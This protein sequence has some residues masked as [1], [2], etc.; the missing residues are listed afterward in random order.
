MSDDGGDEAKIFMTA[1]LSRLM[2]PADANVAGNVHGGI[3]MQMIEESACVAA[4]R[5]FNHCSQQQQKQQQQQQQQN[6]NIIKVLTARAESITFQQ[7]LH[8]GDIAKVQARVVFASEHTVAVAV[9]LMAERLAQSRNAKEADRVGNQ[10]LLWIVGHLSASSTSTT[11]TS[12]GGGMTKDSNGVATVQRN[13]T[14]STTFC[15]AKAPKLDPPTDKEGLMAYHYAA[16]AYQKRKAHEEEQDLASLP[17]SETGEQES[18]NPATED[19]SNNNNNTPLLSPDD[20]AV[21]LAQ[22]MLPAD[23]VTGAGLVRGGVVMRLIDNACGVVAVR[24]CGTNVVTVS[25]D[26]MDLVAPILL[27]DVLRIGARPTFTSHKSMEIQ[28]IVIAERFSLQE[29]GRFA[30]Q[31]IVTTKAF[32]NFV[33]VGRDGKSLP[34][35]PLALKTDKDKKIFQQGKQRYEQR[36]ALRAGKG[37]K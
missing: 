10:A 21:E 8:V 11:P 14:S 9:K 23:C 25:V 3:I 20:S 27:G 34:M 2:V 35:P 37:H 12:S 24:H 17:E 33:S 28:A 6:N 22:V 7:P 31:E 26:A 16:M 15:R 5:F 30:R 19:S 29:N 4:S 13:A 36:K 1:E 32:Y 18:N